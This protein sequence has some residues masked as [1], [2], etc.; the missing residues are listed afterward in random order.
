MGEIVVVFVVALVVFGPEE[1]PRIARF[2]AKAS[3]ELRK[4]ADEVR[5]EFDGV[6]TDRPRYPDQNPPPRYEMRSLVSP[7]LPPAAIIQPDAPAPEPTSTSTSTSAT[8]TPPD[9]NPE[10]P[11]A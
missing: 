11:G 7:P 4:A 9:P 6:L 8:A 3:R 10:K 1:L 2:L 5:G